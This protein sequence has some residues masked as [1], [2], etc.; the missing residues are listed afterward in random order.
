MSAVCVVCAVCVRASDLSD[1]S[2]IVDGGSVSSFL[3]QVFGGSL[4]QLCR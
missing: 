4:F 1:V 2:V 3:S